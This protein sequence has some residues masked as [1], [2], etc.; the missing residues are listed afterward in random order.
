MCAERIEH[1]GCVTGGVGAGAFEP[2]DDRGRDA[3]DSRRN[4]VGG[5]V[6]R[7][8]VQCWHRAGVT[9]SLVVRDIFD[10]VVFCRGAVV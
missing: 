8:D 1:E 4:D 3:Q 10:G 7:I 2:F 9:V 5:G 6:V